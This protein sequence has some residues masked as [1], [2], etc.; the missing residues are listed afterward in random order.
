MTAICVVS[1]LMLLQCSLVYPHTLVPNDVGQ[2]NESTLLQ[3]HPVFISFN[4][5][6]VL[7]TLHMQSQNDQNINV[8]Q[9]QWSGKSLS[10]F[11]W[12]L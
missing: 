8:I 12:N 6:I 4:T 7:S 2:I 11:P 9:S 10:L 1:L 5:E 3:V